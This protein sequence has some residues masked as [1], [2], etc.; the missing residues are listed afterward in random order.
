[1]NLSLT[2]SDGNDYLYIDESVDPQYTF[3][4]NNENCR[5]YRKTITGFECDVYEYDIGTYAYLFP[6]N[7][8]MMYIYGSLAPN[9]FRKL[10]QSLE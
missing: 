1:M 5:V 8:T 10:V 9:E 6:K 7:R 2:Y 4:I 3:N